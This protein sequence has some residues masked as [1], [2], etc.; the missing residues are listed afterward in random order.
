MVYVLNYRDNFLGVKTG[1]VVDG[2]VLPRY[3]FR[4]ART[5]RE[6]GWV[7]HPGPL[8]RR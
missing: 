7:R 8:R 1:W 4:F 2:T 5:G 3:L 6:T